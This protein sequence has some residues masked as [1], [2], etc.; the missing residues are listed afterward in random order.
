MDGWDYLGQCLCVW[1]TTF[2]DLAPVLV[3]YVYWVSFSRLDSVVRQFNLKRA[4]R[5]RGDRKLVRNLP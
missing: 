1:I 4:W 5:A 2:M 3:K